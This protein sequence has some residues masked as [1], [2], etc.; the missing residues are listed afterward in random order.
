MKGHL[1]RP[2]LD[3]AL[4]GQVLHIDLVTKQSFRQVADAGGNELSHSSD[5]RYRHLCRILIANVQNYHPSHL[6]KRSQSL[7]D[8]SLI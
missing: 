7:T 6:R 2:S 3:R 5:S 1:G 4:S 8:G